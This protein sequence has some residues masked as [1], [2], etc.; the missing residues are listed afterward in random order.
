MASRPEDIVCFEVG[1]DNSPTWLPLRTI[2]ADDRTALEAEAAR[3]VIEIEVHGDQLAISGASRVGMV[4]LPSGRRLI[5]RSKISSL[6]ILEWLVFLGEFPRLTAWLPEAGVSVDDEWHQCIGKL[7]LAAVEVITRQHLRRDYT[8]VS[9]Q[10]SAIKGRVLT[11]ALGRRLHRLPKVPQIQRRRTL[12]T[13]FNSVLAIALDRLPILLSDAPPKHRLRLIHLREQW[14]TIRRD[15][16]DPLAAVTAA[17]WASPP[18]YHVA[19]QLARLILAGAGLD[20]KSSMGGRAFTLSLAGVWER[21]L[22]RMFDTVAG[23]RRVAKSKRTRRWDDP[24]GHDDRRRWLIADVIVERPGVRWVLDAK[25]K[26]DFG[27]ESRI[28]RFQMC[29]YAVAFDAD[30]VSLVYPVA[31]T[32]AIAVPRN[33]LTVALGGK[34]VCI[35][36]LALPMADG[37]D[38]CIVALSAVAAAIARSG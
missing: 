26:R 1:S 33:L 15:I 2:L 7:F 8:A 21:S 13:P 6:T 34:Q 23:W 12:D 25:Y 5:I 30:R 9:V 10:D 3:G 38:A 28:D 24:T 32:G 16:D 27:D 4:I 36:S 17:Q 31:T 18:G 35:D 22:L 37:P 29:A 11:V 14:A 19:L 20:P